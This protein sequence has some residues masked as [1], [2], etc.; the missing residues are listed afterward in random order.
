VNE[1]VEVDSMAADRLVT[2][3]WLGGY[4]V[5]VIAGEFLTRVDEPERVGGTNTG[6]QPTDLFLS[7]VASCFVM[8]LA[9][10][11]SKRDLEL[12]SIEVDVIGTYDGPRF[13]KI[14]ISVRI[15]VPEET[16]TTLIASAERV[17]YVTNTLKNSPEINVVNRDPA[18]PPLK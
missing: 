1:I 16:A 7:S 13:S 2:A 11:A 6:P 9:H 17:C 18:L 4:Q 5:D 14:E 15:P 12:S 10:A 8:S 3:R